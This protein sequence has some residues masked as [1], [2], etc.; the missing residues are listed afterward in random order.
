M[1]YQW[2]QV[3]G[4]EVTLRSADTAVARFRTPYVRQNSSLTLVFELTVVDDDGTTASDIVTI[5]VVG[6]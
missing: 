5:M 4:K 6:Q 2:Q 3:S 1:G